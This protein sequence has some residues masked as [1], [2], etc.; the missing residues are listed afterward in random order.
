MTP[1]RHRYPRTTKAAWYCLLLAGLLLVAHEI[2]PPAYGEHDIDRY[3]WVAFLV[4]GILCLLPRY[5]FPALRRLFDVL[6]A[7]RTGQPAPPAEPPPA[8]PEAPNG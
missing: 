2:R 7:W 6:I 8:E 1:H 4:A 5:A 3:G